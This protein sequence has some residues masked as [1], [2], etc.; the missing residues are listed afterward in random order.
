VPAEPRSV[1]DQRCGA[2]ETP[3]REWTLGAAAQLHERRATNCGGCGMNCAQAG[4]TALACAISPF[5]AC[6]VWASV[7]MPASVVA[8]TLADRTKEKAR[9]AMF[10][11]FMVL[12]LGSV[13]SMAEL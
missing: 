8:V 4:R 13:L 10:V 11:L 5:A 9:V 7:S 1:I 6:S 2:S 12:C 3:Q